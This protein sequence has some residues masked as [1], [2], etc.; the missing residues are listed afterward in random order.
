[1]ANAAEKLEPL[2]ELEYWLVPLHDGGQA[3]ALVSFPV[4]IGRG[5]DAD[6]RLDDMHISRRHCEI[7]AGNAA[8]VVRDLGS[9]NGTYVNN[10]RVEA[11]PLGPDDV[12]TIGGLKFVLRARSAMARSLDID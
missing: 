11:S 12:L 6:L 10:V 7:I 5:P 3:L 9:R 4:N 1:M 8:F 2:S